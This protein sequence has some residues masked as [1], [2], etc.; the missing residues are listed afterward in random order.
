MRRKEFLFHLKHDE[1]YKHNE[2]KKLDT[3]ENIVYYSIFTNLEKR[4]NEHM[5]LEVRL[6]VTNLGGRRLLGV[7]VVVCFL[8]KILFIQVFSH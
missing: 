7:L 2:L 5:V 4:Q 8:F 3:K 6:V 1:S